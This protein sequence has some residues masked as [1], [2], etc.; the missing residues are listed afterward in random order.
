MV[1]ASRR[2][3]P[4]SAAVL[5]EAPARE[6]LEFEGVATTGVLRTAAR[7]TA[8]NGVMLERFLFLAPGTPEQ[9]D[10]HVVNFL[11]IENGGGDF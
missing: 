4:K 1:C 2:G 3:P 8:M 9:R 11:I 5:E 7:G 6:P 10:R